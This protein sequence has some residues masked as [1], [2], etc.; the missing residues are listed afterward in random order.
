MPKA[1][2]TDFDHDLGVVALLDQ[3]AILVQQS[4]MQRDDHVIL[5]DAVQVLRVDEDLGVRDRR[6]IDFIERLIRGGREQQLLDTGA[7]SIGLLRSDAAR[8]TAPAQ[9]ATTKIQRRDFM[10][11]PRREFDGTGREIGEKSRRGVDARSA[12]GLFLYRP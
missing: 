3:L 7:S 10:A 1:T 12:C 4:L 8:P 2:G 5:V 9:S 6:Q 11:R